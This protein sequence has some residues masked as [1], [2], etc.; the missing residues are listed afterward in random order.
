MR[1]PESSVLTLL[2][3]E[4]VLRGLGENM[5]EGAAQRLP[6]ARPLD[7]AAAAHRGI[8]LGDGE[9]LEPDALR[10]QRAG[11]QLWRKLRDIGAAP[12]HRLDLGL[13]PPHHLDEKPEQEIGRFLSRGAADDGVGRPGI[14]SLRFR[15]L[16]H[17]DATH[18]RP[19]AQ[20]RVGLGSP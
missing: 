1:K 8:L 7:L 10:L 5:G 2:R 11:H 20:G 3:R 15:L 12:E 18:S 9:K 4:F 13:M 6:P 16:V 14:Q 19:S 17:G